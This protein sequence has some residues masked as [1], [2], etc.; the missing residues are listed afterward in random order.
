MV[1]Q[2]ALHIIPPE[3]NGLYRLKVPGQAELLYIVQG[4]VRARLLAH[5]LK[6]GQPTHR[7][8]TLFAGPLEYS[9][10]LGSS[11]FPHQ[12]LE[13]E[14]DVIAASILSTGTIPQAQF[15]G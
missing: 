6:G 14:N 11:W 9:W 4:L 15:L 2:E 5:L 1:V 12:R 7:Q 13:L 8:S 3:A 10:V